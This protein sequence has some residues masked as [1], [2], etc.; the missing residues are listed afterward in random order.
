MVLESI[1]PHAE[2]GFSLPAG[3]VTKHILEKLESSLILSQLAR[4]HT[5]GWSELHGEYPALTHDS[6]LG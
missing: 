3:C 2:R 4:D 5:Q 1:M 6:A